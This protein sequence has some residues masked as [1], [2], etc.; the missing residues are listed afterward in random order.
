MLP[1]NRTSADVT[2]IR[3]IDAESS[4]ARLI[5]RRFDIR[6]V[7]RFSASSETVRSTRAAS[8]TSLRSLRIIVSA[9]MLEVGL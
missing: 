2:T 8:N 9:M 7:S 3:V 4:S 1:T 5:V 6:P